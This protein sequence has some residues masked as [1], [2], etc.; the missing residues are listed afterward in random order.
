M[1]KIFIVVLLGLLSIN[2]FAYDIEKVKEFDNFYS[3]MTQEVC[4]TSTLFINAEDTMG[5]IKADKEYLI[6]DVRSDGE[7]SVMGVHLQKS[8]HIPLERLFTK[9][10]LDT[11]PKNTPIIVTCHS[12]TRGL[13]A[14]MALKQIGIT[15]TQVLKGGLIALADAN[16]PAN[17]PIK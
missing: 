13:M 9:E 3:K 16:T 11:L 2:S 5:L 7:Y 15:N 4:A 14:V 10:S 6:L 8:L 12:G 1:K 17:A